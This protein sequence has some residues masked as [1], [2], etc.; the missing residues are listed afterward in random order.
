M[1]FTK[2]LLAALMILAFAAVFAAC[3][4][5]TAA[6]PELEPEAEYSDSPTFPFSFTVE[7]LHGNPVTGASLGDRDIFFI[8]YWTTWCPACVNGMPGLAE[9]AEEFGDRVGFL[10]LLGDF[11]TARDTAIDITE[12]ANAP[13]ITVDAQH[14]YF[15]DLVQLMQIRFLPTSIII[16]AEGNI[17]GEH[18]VGSSTDAFRTAI[19]DALNR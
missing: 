8:Y 1:K 7:D 9:L 16:D 6:I 19:E 5:E 11:D 17:I 3:A 18:I 10:S 13:F 4:D 12:G 2:K 15:A 14:P